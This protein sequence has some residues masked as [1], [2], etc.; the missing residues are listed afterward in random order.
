MHISLANPLPRLVLLAGVLLTAGTLTL[1]AL[2]IWLTEHWA[3]SARPEDWIR[4]A[5][6]EPG[7]AAY[8]YR[9][10]H[11]RQ[12]DL[13]QADLDKA[14]QYYLRAIGINPRSA[15]TW[16]DLASVYETQGETARAREAYQKA[17]SL[18]PISADVAWRHGNFLLRQADLVQAFV[19]IR[20]ALDA[21]PRLTLPAIAASWRG[22]GNVERM[23]KEVLPPARDAYL[24]ALNYLRLQQEIGPALIVWQ[25]LL[26]LNQPFEMRSVF[27]LIEDLIRL[28]RLAE[29]KQVWQES[30]RAT[31]WVRNL[32]AS[33]SLVWDGGFEQELMNGGFAWRQ[34]AVAGSSVEFD[35]VTR[36]GGSRALRVSFDGSAN[37]DYTHVFQ[38]VAVEPR[39]R[40]RLSAYLRTE[41]ISTDS[42]LRLSVIDSQHAGAL[43]VSTSNLV[44][45]VPW[46]RQESEFT[47]GPETRLLRIAL[48]R[49]ASRKF[50]NKLRGTVWLDDVSLTPAAPEPA[51]PAS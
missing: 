40:Y 13:E 42:G 24:E 35:T 9:L 6:W 45:S 46:S 3:Q 31:G 36:H 30:L 1:G 34:Q 15:T 11:Y 43:D 49:P 2:K 47:T 16:M 10:G 41:E 14:A 7:N 38:Y 33:D 26:A 51:R 25:R 17:R 44:G 32:A 23:L 20:R 18:Y 50:D 37:P 22:S 48:H 19:E 12:W 29:A 5:E 4:A 27:L 28:D 39:S 8:W 21:D